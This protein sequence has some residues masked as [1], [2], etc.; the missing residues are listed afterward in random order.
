MAERK[1]ILYPSMNCANFESLKDEVLS[2]NEAGADGFHCDISDGTFFSGWSMGLRDVQAIRKNTNKM[3]DVHL[4]VTEPSKIIDQMVKAGVDIFYVFAE[5]EK[6]IA[7]TLYKIR[8]LGKFPGLCVGWN[9]TVENYYDLYPLVDYVMVN[10]TNSVTSKLENGIYDRIL[11][12]INIREKSHLKFKILLDGGISNEV[13]RKTWKMG[14]DGY[15]MGTNCLFNRDKNYKEL[16][17]KIR[18]IEVN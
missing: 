18:D 2:L 11:R 7:H 1:M 10:C 9:A 14:V 12:L 13:I 8:S 5:S 15:A 6:V 16:F 4:Y 17:K 3:V